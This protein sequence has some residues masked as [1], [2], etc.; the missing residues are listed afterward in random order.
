MLPEWSTIQIRIEYE[1]RR[2]AQFPHLAPTIVAQRLLVSGED[3]RHGSHPGFD[4]IAI[5]R[6]CWRR[7]IQESREGA[8]TI[9]QQIVRVVTNRYER[10]LTRKIREIVLAVLVARVYPKE[11]HPAIYLAIGYYGWRMNGYVQACRK[12]GYS[13]SRLT[14][15][16]AARLVARLKYPQPKDAPIGRM[17]QIERRRRHL[18]RLHD[19]HICGKTYRHLDGKA[20]CNAAGSSDTVPQF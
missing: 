16:E 4:V 5:L 2:L 13:P 6:A 11:L 20:V 9:E 12:L 1:C 7:I 18:Q 15:E 10:T 3:H 8:S 19:R 14:M 17:I